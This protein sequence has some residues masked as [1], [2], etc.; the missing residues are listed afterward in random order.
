[1]LEEESILGPLHQLY[2]NGKREFAVNGSEPQDSGGR[3]KIDFES[4]LRGIS[5]GF[6]FDST[7]SSY[8]KH[9][10][11]VSGIRT[12]SLEFIT[13]QKSRTANLTGQ[14]RASERRNRN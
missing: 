2:M 8:C 6:V 1:M 3:E 11:P 10:V 9:M 7:I 5:C 4:R 12:P 14:C 13:R